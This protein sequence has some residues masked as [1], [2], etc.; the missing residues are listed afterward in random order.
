[1]SEQVDDL[2]VVVPDE[3]PRLS[4]TGRRALLRILVD[5]AEQEWGPD[6]RARLRELR[7]DAEPGDGLASITTLDRKAGGGRERE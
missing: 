6:W 1:M 5:A 3:P 2:R 7:D 4:P